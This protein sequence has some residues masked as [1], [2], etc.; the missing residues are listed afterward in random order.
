MKNTQK[1]EVNS[2]FRKPNEKCSKANIK[3]NIQTTK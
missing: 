1:I 3:L 2:N